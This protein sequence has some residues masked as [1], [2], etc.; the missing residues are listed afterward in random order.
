MSN[1]VKIVST[2]VEKKVLQHSV[3]QD[4]LHVSTSKLTA[5]Q[6]FKHVQNTE[7]SERMFLCFPTWW[8]P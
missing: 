3:P 2:L 1:T 5:A 7:V 8:T 4:Y 6:C